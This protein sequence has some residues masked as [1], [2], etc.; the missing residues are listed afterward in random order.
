[1]DDNLRDNPGKEIE[2]L[3]TIAEGP[4]VVLH[5]R[6]R[7]KPGDDPVALVHIFRIEDGRIRELWDLG[8][9]PVTDS[10]NEAGLF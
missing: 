1:M 10:P 7:H 9:Q 5:G 3:R 2:I 4:L 8:Q 6:V